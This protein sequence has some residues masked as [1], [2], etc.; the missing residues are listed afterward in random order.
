VRD[1][2]SLARK[3]TD[4]KREARRK[5]FSFLLAMADKFE[6]QDEQTLRQLLED[7]T[8]YEERQKIRKAIRNI[9]KAEGRA[10]SKKTGTAMYR[11][12]GTFQPP[13]QIT[14][15]NSVTGNVLPDRVVTETNKTEKG[16]GGKTL[17]YLNARTTQPPHGYK[18][19]SKE[20]T[21][22]TYTPVI[23]MG[24]QSPSAYLKRSPLNSV[25]STQSPRGSPRP[26][27]SS[28]Q[29]ITPEPPKVQGDEG[30]DVV[31][32]KRRGMCKTVLRGLPWEV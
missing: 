7:A 5:S 30:G 1:C 4:C 21:E 19:R 29:S 22:P 10:P 26:S 24:R 17:S 32:Q 6:G 28:T 9:K 16:D 20:K 12:M 8:D 14:I 25:G 13:K 18:T 31:S 27:V 11:R 23:P 2:T 3:A 15:P